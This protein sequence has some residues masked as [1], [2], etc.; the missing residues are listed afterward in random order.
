MSDADQPVTV[1]PG[2]ASRLTGISTSTLKQLCEGQA[3]PGVVRVDRYTYRLRTDLLPTIEQVQHILDERI[4]ID[5]RRVRAAFARVQVELEAVGNDIAELEDDP[6][7]R[8]GVDLAAFDA[9]TISGHST[10][11]QALARLT[12]AKMDLQVNSQM[13]RELRPGR[14]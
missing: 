14:Y 7:A 1:T 11:R 8:I 4:R 5:V 10:L 9:Y 2:E 6:S 3:L 13:A 12:D